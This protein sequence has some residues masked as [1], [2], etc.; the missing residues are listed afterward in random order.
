[1]V[2]SIIQSP[3]SG[4]YVTNRRYL[5]RMCGVQAPFGVKANYS[6]AFDKKQAP[7]R[8]RGLL[9]PLTGRCA[10]SALKNF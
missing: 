9:C 4:V 6:V 8:S 5:T 3:P 2:I 7:G 10:L 1:M